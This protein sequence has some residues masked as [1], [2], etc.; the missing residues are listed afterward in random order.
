MPH[1][2]E[3]LVVNIFGAKATAVLTNVPGPA[4]TLYFAGSRIIDIMFWVPQ[5][6]RLGLGISILSYDGQ[7]RMGVATDAGL[8]PDPDSSS[9]P[10]TR[11]WPR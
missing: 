10:F 6:G 2:L 7:V 5:S 8:V 3:D 1:R 4:P 9:P 11:N